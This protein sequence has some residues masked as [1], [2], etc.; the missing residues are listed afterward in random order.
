M[1]IKPRARTISR[2]PYLYSRE[3]YPKLQIHGTW[4]HAC[5]IRP[6]DVMRIYNPSKGQL[7]A[8]SVLVPETKIKL[9][10]LS[11]RERIVRPGLNERPLLE[12]QGRWFKAC[13]FNEGD[14]VEVSSPRY[15]VVS[16]KVIQ[17]AR[18]VEEDK[19]GLALQGIAEWGAF[20]ALLNAAAC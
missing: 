19:Y 17:T 6:D 14:K 2:A 8:V 10:G 4:L 9:P 18:S 5:G 11:I 3:I 7:V 12:L 20:E 13:G 16:V 15:M 1:N